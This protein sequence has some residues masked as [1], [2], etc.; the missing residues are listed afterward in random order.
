MHEHNDSKSVPVSQ[1]SIQSDDLII[2][3]NNLS[4]KELEAVSDLIYLL[5]KPQ[6]PASDTMIV[7]FWLT[8]AD[9]LTDKEYVRFCEKWDVGGAK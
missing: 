9:R 8:L 5:G 3:L 2:V 6:T 1:E 7:H 4:K